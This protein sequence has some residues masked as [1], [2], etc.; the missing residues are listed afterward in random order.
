MR[1]P[2][3]ARDDN[4]QR[5]CR[6]IGSP[7]GE[8]MPTEDEAMFNKEDLNKLSAVFMDNPRE[9]NLFTEREV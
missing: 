8:K 1:S 7:E 2:H 3:F 4:F 9:L 6:Q 5:K